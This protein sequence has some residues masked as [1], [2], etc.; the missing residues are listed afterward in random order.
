MIR[1]VLVE[2]KV[3][4]GL[5]IRGVLDGQPDMEIVA[6]VRTADDAIAIAEDRAPDV[7]LLDV[8]LQEPATSAATHRLAQE[9]PESGIVVVAVN[10]P[11]VIRFQT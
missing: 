11:H 9:V 10:H 8:E 4:A 6:E 7:F 3:L 5:G 2:P 1:I